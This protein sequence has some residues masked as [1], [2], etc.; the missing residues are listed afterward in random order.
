MNIIGA[1]GDDWRPDRPDLHPIWWIGG[2]IGA[3]VFY[4]AVAAI[5][6]SIV[7]GNGSPYLN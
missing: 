4:I 2:I 6:G 1:R 3:V 5:I 7:N